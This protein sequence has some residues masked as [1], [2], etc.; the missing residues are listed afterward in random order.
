MA[1]KATVDTNE[2]SKGLKISDAE[3]EALA[4]RKN[5]FHGEWNSELQPRQFEVVIL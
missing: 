2:Y 3:M 1:I 4:I 5:A